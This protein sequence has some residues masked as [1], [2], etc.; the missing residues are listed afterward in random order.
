MKL[1]LDHVAILT[2]SLSET[3]RSLPADL[4]RYEVEEFPG[5]GTK[6]QYIGLNKN[7]GPCLLLLEAISEGPYK[8]SLAKRGPGLHHLGCKVESI[9]LAV[10]HF[11]EQG[12]LLHPISL[13]TIKQGTVWMCRPGTPFLLELTEVSSG[14][15]ETE[16]GFELAIPAL[17]H[18]IDWIPGITLLMSDSKDLVIKIASTEITVTT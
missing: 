1:R 3:E 13:K 17:S 15:E 9:D 16:T 6:E 11:A 7:G 8:R 2:R 10:S 4:E 5:E 18:Q 14:F 12:L